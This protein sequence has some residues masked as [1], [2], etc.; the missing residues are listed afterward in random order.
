[1]ETPSASKFTN[2]KITTITGENLAPSAPLISVNVVI[3]PS[4]AP[5]TI[6]AM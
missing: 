3:I 2:P 1:M 6:S 5:Y 4:F